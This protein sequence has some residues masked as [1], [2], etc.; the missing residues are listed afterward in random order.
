MAE[1]LALPCP[2]CHYY[3]FRQFFRHPLNIPPDGK[4]PSESLSDG[5]LLQIQPISFK[6]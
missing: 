3:C 5:I 6:V 1:Y 4:M 2:D